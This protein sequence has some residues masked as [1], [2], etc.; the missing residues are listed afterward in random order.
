MNYLL[1]II[2]IIFVVCMID[3]YKKGFV[4]KIASLVGMLLLIVVV[5]HISPYV[6]NV[7]I[8]NTTWDENLQS[9]IG[10]F[11]I[12][13]NSQRDNTIEQNQ[14]ETIAS[15][16]LPQIVKDKLLENNKEDIYNQLMVTIFEDYVG[17][18]LAVLIIKIASFIITLIV[19]GIILQLIIMSFRLVTRLPILNGLNKLAGVA[20]GF[21]EGIVLT[22]LFFT[23]VTIFATKPWGQEVFQMIQQSEILIY[24]YN[25]NYILDMLLQYI[26]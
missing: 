5:I 2:G 24:L 13:Q 18:F 10:D 15:Y 11:L 21:V 19:L 22:W 9:K 7:I 20:S 8:K 4:N 14:K 6:S 12:E 23:V 1:I 26:K 16:Q 17:A 25:E 3:G